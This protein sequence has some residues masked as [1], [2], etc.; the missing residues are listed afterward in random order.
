[1]PRRRLGALLRPLLLLAGGTLSQYTE[2]RGVLAGSHYNALSREPTSQEFA[3]RRCTAWQ[4]MSKPPILRC[5][6][7]LR[8]QHDLQ[9]F[10]S[11]EI[12]HVPTH[13]R[14]FEHIT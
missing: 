7:F 6:D 3:D 9:P 13:F 2:A 8:V 11:R 12:G 4:A 1:M 10:G 5:A 14:A